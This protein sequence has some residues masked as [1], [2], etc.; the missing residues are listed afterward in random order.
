MTI[1]QSALP[2]PEDALEGFL[3]KE[4]I[5]YHYHKHHAAYHNNLKAVLPKE[6]EGLSLKEI[7][8][9]S[10]GVVFNNAA[11]AWNHRFFWDCL[12]PK[13]ADNP[14]PIDPT[15]LSRIEADF[16]SFE[17]FKEQFS[18]KAATLF[19]AGWCW[20]AENREGKLEIMPLKDADT[21]LVHQAKPLLTIDVWEHAYYLDYQNRRADHLK[22]LWSI[23][24]W[25]T[26]ETRYKE[27]INN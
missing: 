24:D 13:V 15:L 14:A 3:S 2:Y 19:G 5:F 23:I 4:Q 26:I 21:P 22:A 27:I 25:P 9:Q 10:D 8:Q 7:V 17:S 6:M 20:L 1:E 12:T 16:G 18:K 11:Q